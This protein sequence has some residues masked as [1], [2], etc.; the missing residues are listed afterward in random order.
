MLLGTLKVAITVFILYAKCVVP[1]MTLT[2]LVGYIPRE[3]GTNPTGL[4]RHCP[5]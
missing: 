3:L 5:N 1:F 2:L 4:N